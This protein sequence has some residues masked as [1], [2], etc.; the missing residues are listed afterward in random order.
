MDLCSYWVRGAISWK[1]AKHTCIT[2]SIMESEFI[3]LKL[4]EQ[5]AEWLRSLLEDA[6]LWRASV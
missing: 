1:F 2:K 4:A 5:E 6:P 3:A